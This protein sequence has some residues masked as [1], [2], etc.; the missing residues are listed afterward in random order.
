MIEPVFDKDCFKALSVFAMSPGSRF[1]RE[2]I[3]A[4]TRLNNVPLDKALVKLVN[5]RILKME[6]NLYGIEFDSEASKRVI[7]AVIRQYKELR[8]IPLDV[9]LILADIVDAMATVKGIEVYLFGSYA[10]LIY[11]EK[12]DVDVA[13]VFERAHHL[14]LARLEQK[15]EKTY[16]KHVQIHDFDKGPFYNNKNDP[17]VSDILRNGV[18]LL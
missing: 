2:E 18:R 6:K 15:L 13:I 17:L 12:S 14:D 7:D 5:C 10:K 4:K 9:F 1:R 3:K 11:R 8:E 16:G